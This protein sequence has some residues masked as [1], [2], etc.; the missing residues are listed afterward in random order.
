MPRL[1]SRSSFDFTDIRLLQ[2]GSVSEAVRLGL[3]RE[4]KK[5]SARAETT[6][7]E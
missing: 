1:K 3:T 5:E 7:Q 6:E 2:I 4:G